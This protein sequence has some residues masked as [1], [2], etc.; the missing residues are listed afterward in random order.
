LKRAGTDDRVRGAFIYHSAGTGR[1]QS[2]GVNFANMPR[3]RR[4]FDD[5]KPDLAVLF[6]TIRT[7]N[8]QA[9]RMLY[10]DELGKPLHLLSDVIR[11][12]IWSAPGHELVQADYSGIEGAVAAWLAGEEWKVAA[13]FE[14]IEDPKLP[15]LY[16]RTAA[17]IMN[18]TTDVI[19]KKHPL[20]QSVGKTSELALGFG[21]GVSAFHGMAT[22]YGVDLDSIH[23]PVWAAAS[24]E[25]RTKAVDRYERCLKT[26]DAKTDALSRNAWIAC[27]II[28]LGWRK[29]NSKIAAGWHICESAIREAVKNP[30]VKQPALKSAYLVSNGFLWCRLP[31]GRCLAYGAPRLRAQVWACSKDADGEWLPPEVMPRDIAE[32]L[33]LEGSVKIEGDTS[34]SATVVSVDSKTKRWKRHA[35]YGGLAFQNQ[36]QAIARDLLANG[37]LKAEAAGYPIIAHVYDEMICEVPNGYGDLAAFEKLICDLPEWAAGMP[38]SAGGWRGKRYRK[39]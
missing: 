28:K 12:F 22:L 7:E 33:A 6:D 26:L 3:P 37:M 31:S 17:G 9:L 35:L 16:R 27:E 34:P 15:D 4:I 5:A 36:V 13:L 29:Q 39:D 23:D 2:T 18:M 10:G 11:G 21:G 25:T 32:K 30:G 24:P 38:L 20:R 14:I 8:P 1:W 19:T